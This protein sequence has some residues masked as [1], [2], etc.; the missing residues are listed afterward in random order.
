MGEPRVIA[1]ERPAGFFNR[2]LFRFLWLT[3]GIGCRLWFR[4]RV[5]GRPTLKGGYV[6]A[7]N[8]SSFLDPILLSSVCWRRIT[9]MMTVIVFRSPWLGWFYRSQRAIPLEVRGGNRDALRAARAVLARG[10]VLGIFPEGGISRDGELMLGS[11]GAVSLGLSGGVPIVPVA[12][13]GAHDAFPP[14]AGFP[15]FRRVTIVFGEPIDPEA[16][17]VGANRRERLAIATEQIMAKIAAL[18]STPR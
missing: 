7:V 10:E 15:R 6:I 12:I 1:A 17:G 11:P 8:H 4:I 18:R 5:V 14:G 16:I 3:V 9:F 2:L 13:L